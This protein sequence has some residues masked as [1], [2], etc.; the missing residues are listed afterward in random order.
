GPV[1]AADVTEDGAPFD[2]AALAVE[3]VAE[4]VELERR[5]I[6]AG[7]VDHE[8]ALSPVEELVFELEVARDEPAEP[9][10]DRGRPEVEREHVVG[11]A[12][13]DDRAAGDRNESERRQRRPVLL[14]RSDDR[15]DA[16]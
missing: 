13:D 7:P 9:A 10:V 11:D 1:G 3:Q 14:D 16:A 8:L 12:A 5:E 15:V 2:D 6:D 4:Q